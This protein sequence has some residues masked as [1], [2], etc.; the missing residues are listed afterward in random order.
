MN[1]YIRIEIQAV[2]VHHLL[3]AEMADIQEVLAEIILLNSSSN[4]NSIRNNTDNMETTTTNSTDKITQTIK[5][6]ELKSASFEITS[7]FS[8]VVVSKFKDYYFSFKKLL[9]TLRE[10]MFRNFSHAKNFINILK[11]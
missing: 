5:I 4:N 10:K 1:I 8:Y 2:V 9:K 3:Q 11:N 7:F 6:G